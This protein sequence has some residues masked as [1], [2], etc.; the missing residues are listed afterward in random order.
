MT[1]AVCTI[2][3]KKELAHARTLMRSVA[4]HHPAWERHVLVLDEFEGSFDPARE[5]F[6]VMDIRHLPMPDKLGTLFFYDEVEAKASAKPWLMAW[7]FDT[8][9]FD[10][11]VFLGPE[12]RLYGPLAAV[13]EALAA[14]APLVLA[15]H[16]TGDLDNESRPSE[17]DILRRGAHDT[18]LVAMARRHPALHELLS[19]WQLRAYR[20]F[21]VQPEAGMYLD[22]RWLDMAAARWGAVSVH[23]PGY[24]VAYWNL[25]HRRVTEVGGKY[26]VE[27]RPLVL[28][29][30]SGFDP[31]AELGLSRADTRYAQA[32]SLPRA[33]ERLVAEYRDE[34]AANGRTRCAAWPYAFG[35]FY[36][37]TPIIPAVRSV[38]RNDVAVRDACGDNPFDNGPGP[39]MARL[40]DHACVTRLMGEIWQQRPD[41]QS[42]FPKIDG[43]NAEGFAVWFV[44]SGASEC[45]ATGEY[46]DPVRAALASG[47]TV[48]F[49]PVAS[50][51]PEPPLP[52]AYD[53]VDKP[54]VGRV[55]RLGAWLRSQAPAGV[56]T[57]TVALAAKV[58]RRN[59]SPEPNL[60]LVTNGARHVAIVSPNVPATPRT[61]PRALA[62]PTG[63][64]GLNIAGY[65]TAD[66]G[67]GQSARLAAASASA[68]EIDFC[69]IDYSSGTT[70]KKSDRTWAHK[71]STANPYAV[72]LLHINADQQPSFVRAMGPAFFSGKYNIGYWHWELPELPDAWLSSFATLDE[73]W[74]PTQF[75]LAAVSAKSPIP[76]VLVPH[77]IHFETQDA[78]RARFGLPEGPYLFLTMFDMYSHQER[79]NPF[80]V[81]DAFRRAF[82]DRRDVALV[83]KIMNGAERPDDLLALKRDLADLPAAVLIESTLS[84]QDVYDLEAACDCFVSLHRSEGF[85]LGLAESMF[86]GKPVVGTNWSGNADFM[87][88][89]NSCPVDYELVTLERDYGPYA[90]GQVWA[91]ADVEHA[92]WY[93]KQLADDRAFSARIGARARHTM[94]TTYSPR[95]IGERYKRRLELIG[96]TR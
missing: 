43:A 89:R 46:I 1:T 47:Q 42:S 30:F 94:A 35:R 69:V 59:A 21:V 52:I 96:R 53:A 44:N 50:P 7:L 80:A 86:L 16:L 73:I 63:P 55:R 15:P 28:F 31:E 83:I 70:S 57:R 66:L 24:D 41:L 13:L 85:G 20:M 38:Y 18:G 2:I 32:G 37:G 10:E 81:I 61:S 39:F 29:H 71:L 27:G 68:A 11:V 3:S 60:A 84:R 62:G 65:V 58:A 88:H 91:D 78:S 93:M 82:G 5:P 40:A 90:R 64:K 87:T 77:A 74:V 76:V 8:R 9:G 6:V 22:H 25:P 33:V 12:T 19:W 51:P 79:K 4:T 56:V 72:N 23:D 95:A 75:V 48:P 17:I 92:A 54:R 45:G 26:F 34:L 14:G 67:V 36:D 49:V